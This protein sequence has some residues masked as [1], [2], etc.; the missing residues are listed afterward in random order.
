M[1]IN[2]EILARKI[3]AEGEYFN[4]QIEK[5]IGKSIDVALCSKISQMFLQTK[6]YVLSLAHARNLNPDFIQLS[7]LFKIKLMSVITAVHQFNLVEDPSTVINDDYLKRL[8]LEVYRGLLVADFDNLT[9]STIYM[10][11][12]AISMAVFLLK[13]LKER[14][15]QGIKDPLKKDIYER[16]IGHL[17]ESMLSVIELFNN[18]CY[19][20]AMSVFRQAL[21][22]F[23]TMRTLEMYPEALQS[24]LEHQAVTIDDALETM[25]KKAL[26]E[27]IAANNLTYNNYK[28]Y[29]NYG[30]LDAI[31]KF[32]ELKKEN[33]RIKYSIKTTSEISDSMEFYDAMNFASNYVHSNFVFVNIDWN[34]VMSEV[35]DGTYQIIDWLT[36]RAIKDNPNVLLINDINYYELYLKEKERCLSIIKRDDYKFN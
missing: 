6:D 32:R 35:L 17:I 2:D 25:S 5:N 36:L 23:I 33:P 1:A 15:M 31:E 22:I 34:I 13:E 16:E 14:G 27:Y 9:G 28:S 3:L 8:L 30:W 21:E 4:R 26:D 12:P 18:K 11:N 24:F 10:S 19:P 20:Q 29:L 7:E